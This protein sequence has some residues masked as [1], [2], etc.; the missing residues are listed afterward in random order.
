MRV[1]QPP[2]RRDQPRPV[3]SLAV[4]GRVQDKP[5]GTRAEQIEH[6]VRVQVHG[7]TV[8]CCRSVPRCAAR[9]GR[10]QAPS[11]SRSSASVSSPRPVVRVCLARGSRN[12]QH[13]RPRPAATAATC[14]AGEI[15][16]PSGELGGRADMSPGERT[17]APRR[18]VHASAGVA[19]G[20][21]CCGAA[22][23]VSSS[24]SVPAYT[25]ATASGVNCRA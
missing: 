9:P 8:R 12:A 18:R 5:P 19:A 4:A 25:T 17:L 15:R 6:S 13:Q 23:R 2:V 7:R 21:G 24:R 16:Q 20:P 22:R 10:G 3:Q 11:P 14:R 1:E